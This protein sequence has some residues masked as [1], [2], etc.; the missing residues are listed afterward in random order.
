[1]RFEFSQDF[2]TCITQPNKRHFSFEI[3]ETGKLDVV[4]HEYAH[5]YAR[6]SFGYYGGHGTPWKRACGIVGCS[7][8]IYYNSQAMKEEEQRNAPYY[9]IYSVGEHICHPVFGSGRIEQITAYSHTAVLR[10]RFSNG[11]VRKID[12]VWLKK[13]QHNTMGI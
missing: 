8:A 13:N 1:M 5:Y 3:S 9:S 10:V 11:D 7:P 12:E 2:F 4:R 6:V